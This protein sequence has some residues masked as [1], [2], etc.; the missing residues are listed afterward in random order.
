MA[1][2]EDQIIHRRSKNAHSNHPPPSWSEALELNHYNIFINGE[3]LY[4]QYSTFITRNDDEIKDIHADLI[5]TFEGEVV[6]WIWFGISCF[7]GTMRGKNYNG[8]VGLR[9]RQFN[10]EIGDDHTLDQFFNDTRFNGYFI[11]EVHTLSSGLIPNARRDYFVEN[12]ALNEFEDA[13]KRYANDTLSK[14]CREG[15]KLNSAYRTIK[16]FEDSQAEYKEKHLKGFSSPKE[17]RT[18]ADALEKNKQRAQAAEKDLKKIIGQA[19][20]SVGSSL[21]KMT[22]LIQREHGREQI[23]SDRQ[24]ALDFTVDPKRKSKPKLMVDELTELKKSERKLVSTI[25]EIIRENLPPDFSEELI[26]KI[27]RELGGKA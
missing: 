16:T 1:R 14:L 27:H 8:L 11:G 3:Q 5:R 7:K 19:N 4:R 6:A 26:N 17:E 20:N 15:S 10:I 9:L 2:A 18:L 23:E 21:Q 25:Y 12:D 24:E 13:F 22:K